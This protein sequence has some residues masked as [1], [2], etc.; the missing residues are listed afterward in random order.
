MYHVI[1]IEDDPMV[2]SINKNYLLSNPL[3]ILDG[4]FK[5]GQEAL[6]YLSC[7]TVDL[8]IVDYFMPIM[9]GKTF[10]QNCILNNYPF[11]FIMITAANNIQDFSDILRLGALDYIVKPFTYE[12]FSQSVQK[13]LTLRTKLNGETDLTQEAIDAIISSQ[14]LPVDSAPSMKGIQPYTLDAI[15]DYLAKEPGHFFSCDEIASAVKLSRITIRRYLNYLLDTNVITSQIDY[16]TG[17]RPSVRYS[18]SPQ[19]KH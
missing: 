7:H 16:N 17:G 3:F 4:V 14:S 18:L 8:A 6:D 1:I 9:D 13:F 2:A 19:R 12:R 10:I 5:N 11:S 15:K